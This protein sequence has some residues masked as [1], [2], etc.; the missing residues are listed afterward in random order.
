MVLFV[1]HY[2]SLGFDLAP[3]VRRV[4]RT[5]V[6]D[7]AKLPHVF[8]SLSANQY[9]AVWIVLLIT[10]SVTEERPNLPGRRNVGL[11]PP[12]ATMFSDLL[13]FQL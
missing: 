13:E 7:C 3:L 9:D 4:L 2:L 10:Y 6:G 1:H 11:Y 12:V 5:F 8:I